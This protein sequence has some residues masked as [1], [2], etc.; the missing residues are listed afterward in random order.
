MQQ[1]QNLWSADRRTPS[2]S[3]YNFSGLEFHRF[4]QS[5]LVWKP[6]SW[7]VIGIEPVSITK[8]SLVS[9]SKGLGLVWYPGLKLRTVRFWL[10]LWRDVEVVQRVTTSQNQLK[11]PTHLG[12]FHFSWVHSSTLIIQLYVGYV[13]NFNSSSVSLPSSLP[14]IEVTLSTGENSWCFQLFFWC[15]GRNMLWCFRHLQNTLKNTH[16]FTNGHC[17]GLHAC[18]SSQGYEHREGQ[19]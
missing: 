6:C 1:I 9:F 17:Q 5:V 19:G 4:R 10:R 16:W 18:H 13:N 3:L 15:L 11:C 2:D 14:F 8:N 7:N 12:R